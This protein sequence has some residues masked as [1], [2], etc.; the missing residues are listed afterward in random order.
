MSS[1]YK[2]HLTAH[3]REL[4]IFGYVRMNSYNTRVPLD[5][6]RLFLM[7]FGDNTIY[8]K[9]H[10]DDYQALLH[11]KVTFMSSSSLKIHNIEFKLEIQ[12]SLSST[13]NTS[14]ILSVST[15]SSNETDE[16]YV[17]TRYTMY[18]EETKYEYRKFTEKT[19]G[20][21]V[22]WSEDYLIMSDL[23]QM[24]LDSL[25]FVC[26]IEIL[27]VYQKCDY[28]V[29]GVDEMIEAYYSNIKMKNKVD[30]K[31]FINDD[32]VETKT[33]SLFEMADTDIQDKT[34]DFRS[35]YS[36]YIDDN[37]CL[38]FT[39]TKKRF[40]VQLQLLALPFGILSVIAKWQCSIFYK[41]KY[42]DKYEEIFDFTF[43]NDAVLSH[44]WNK[45]DIIDRFWTEYDK[46]DES[47][48][49]RQ[50]EENV[51]LRERYNEDIML[52]STIEI[53]IVKEYNDNI[54]FRDNWSLYGIDVVNDID[55]TH[56]DGHIVIVSDFDEDNFSWNYM[57][58]AVR[59]EFENKLNAQRSEYEQELNA[60][61]R[62][63]TQLKAKPIVIDVK[64]NEESAQEV[65]LW[66]YSI[67]MSMYCDTFIQNG[68]DSIKLV[69]EVNDKD[70]LIDIGITLKAHQI[71][72]MNAIKKLPK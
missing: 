6:I 18:C 28:N 54:V 72:V 11:P 53:M 35:Y 15:V 21:R 46:D 8:W 20:D 44:G 62:E 19:T 27:H 45:K 61:K 58:S 12:K 69:Q 36:P 55:A 48:A 66:L 70:D 23:K 43:D 71:A 24:D 68:F 30:Y 40:G 26:R 2:S 10:G 22:E 63:M 50:Y 57:I 5:I 60:L 65:S 67:G 59:R 13:G 56:T 17:I 14:L 47:K 7:M 64:I 37:W 49:A 3:K 4:L 34:Q 52:H 39:E 25:T 1:F 9:I 38:L 16:Q 41:G 33:H 51:V 42:K 31:W 32:S 29:S